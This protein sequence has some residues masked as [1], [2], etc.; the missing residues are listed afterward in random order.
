[1][2]S[3]QMPA[4]VKFL[5]WDPEAIEEYQQWVKLER[6]V[7]QEQEQNKLRWKHIQQVSIAMMRIQAKYP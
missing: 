4:N 3:N 7:R 6:V 5:N 1:M 2:K